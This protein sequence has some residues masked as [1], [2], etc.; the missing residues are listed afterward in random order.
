MTLA[1]MLTPYYTVV[2][3]RPGGQYKSVDAGYAADGSEASQGSGGCLYSMG[4]RCAALLGHGGAVQGRKPA[5]SAAV[6]SRELVRMEM[7]FKTHGQPVHM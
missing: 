7:A 2:Y 5:G 3:I 1:E 4:L 6:W